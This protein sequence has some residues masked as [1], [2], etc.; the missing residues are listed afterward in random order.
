VRFVRATFWRT[1]G[2]LPDEDAACRCHPSIRVI[3]GQPPNPRNP[4]SKTLYA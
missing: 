4:Q 3:R 1:A 2:Q